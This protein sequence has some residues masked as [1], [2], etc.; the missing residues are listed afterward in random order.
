MYKQ[1]KSYLFPAIGWDLWSVGLTKIVRI[2]RPMHW[3]HNAFKRFRGPRSKF[4]KS[5]RRGLQDITL[6]FKNIIEFTQVISIS[7]LL[8]N[9]I[10]NVLY[11]NCGQKLIFVKFKDLFAEVTAAIWVTFF[12]VPLW[13]MITSI[14]ICWSLHFPWFSFKYLFS[15]KVRLIDYWKSTGQKET[16]REVFPPSSEIDDLKMSAILDW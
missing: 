11:Q 16:R 3:R 5:A 2:F 13:L 7:L 9:S 15:F 6:F 12:K 10:P 4:L 1:V 14:K 8:S